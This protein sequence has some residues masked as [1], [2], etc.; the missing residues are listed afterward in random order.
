MA[1]EIESPA[2]EVIHAQGDALPAEQSFARDPILNSPYEYPGRHWDMDEN[3]LPTQKI[4]EFRRPSSLKSPIVA[5]RR[6]SG[7]L[8]QGELF[9]QEENGVDYDTN[10]FTNSIHYH[11][12]GRFG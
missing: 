5:N 3:N 11:P 1:T 7:N 6:G 9:A 10:D 12:I 2:G 4:N 8:N